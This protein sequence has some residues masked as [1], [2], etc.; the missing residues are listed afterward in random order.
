MQRLSIVILLIILLSGC[1]GS[2]QYVKQDPH[3]KH[4]VWS[5]EKAERKLN[6]QIGR[7]YD[8]QTYRRG[9]K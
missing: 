9:C 3:W 8:K 7:E 4:K 5:S 6:H 2:G 1:A